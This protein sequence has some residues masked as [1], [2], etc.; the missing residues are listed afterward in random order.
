MTRGMIVY[1]RLLFLLGVAGLASGAWSQQWQSY[2]LTDFPPPGQVRE[3]SSLADSFGNHH[4]YFYVQFHPLHVPSQVLFYMRTDF[5]GNILTDTVRLNGFA[6]NQ[7]APRCIRA[8]GNGS[9]SWCVFGERVPTEQTRGLFLTERDENGQEVMPP[10]LLGYDGAWEGWNTS[11][12]LD[13]V[14]NIIHLVGTNTNPCYYY[15]FT[16]TAETLQWQRPINGMLNQGLNTS[17][18]LSPVD[19]LPWASMITA[20]SEMG[21]LLL[22]RFN[23][24]SSQTVYFPLEDQSIGI[25]HNGFGMDANGRLDIRGGTDTVQSAYFHVDSTFQ[26]IIDQQTLSQTVAGFGALQT[27]SAGNCLMVWS[28]GVYGLRWAYR[29]ADGQWMPR[30]A[31]I[32]TNMYLNFFSIVNMENQRLAFTAEGVRRS[33]DFSQVYLYTCGFPPNGVTTPK[34]VT[35]SQTFSAYPNPF[36]SSLQLTLPGLPDQTVILYDILGRTVWTQRVLAGVYNLNV[37]DPRLALLPFG[38]YF[39]ALQGHSQ[40]VPIQITHIK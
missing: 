28:N 3:C 1:R 40:I 31:L 10:T 5:Y 25:G 2:Q 19:G 17:M 14:N 18:I 13:P 34:P 16:T 4:H 7:P 27:D 15:R 20:N 35:L 22:V 36:G 23:E 32:D 8:V 24:D 29:R 21:Y 26:N 6:G 9:H 38:T 33:E 37:T 39:L 12:L 30:P 11:A